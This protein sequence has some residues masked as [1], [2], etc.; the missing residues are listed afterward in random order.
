MK[1]VI[2]VPQTRLTKSLPQKSTQGGHYV[3]YPKTSKSKK[4][5]TSSR[6]NLNKSITSTRL[7]FGRS[8]SIQTKTKILKKSRDK[9]FTEPEK[10]VI[11]KLAAIEHDRWS[12]QARTALDNMT[13]ERRTRWNKLSKTPY[14]KLT[15]EMREKDREQVYN[16]WPIIREYINSLMNNKK[17][18]K[19]LTDL[20]VVPRTPGM[21]VESA[22]TKTFKIVD[23]KQVLMRPDQKQKRKDKNNVELNIIDKKRPKA[24]SRQIAMSRTSTDPTYA[25]EEMY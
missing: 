4:Q 20:F 14:K 22:K 21:T 25:T 2:F 5:G 16:Y 15:E 9:L 18:R 11:D 17:L 8:E 7:L 19:G 13:D 3:V 6:T 23:P 24:V 1:L 12:G 10:V